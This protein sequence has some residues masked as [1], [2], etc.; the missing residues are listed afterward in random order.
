MNE[1]SALVLIAVI[2]VSGGLIIGG[3]IA[4]YQTEKRVKAEIVEYIKEHKKCP[5][6]I[7]DTIEVID[8]REAK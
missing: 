4:D 7:K 8:L 3:C 2:G 1:F 5:F 6:E